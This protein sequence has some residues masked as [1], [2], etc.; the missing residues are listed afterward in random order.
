MGVLKPT[1]SEI[2]PPR[3]AQEFADLKQQLVE[4]DVGH[5]T[6]R[7]AFGDEELGQVQLS[8]SQPARLFAEPDAI[9]RSSGGEL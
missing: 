5:L 4:A 2:V 1:L 7:R 3:S 6:V 9:S 8:G